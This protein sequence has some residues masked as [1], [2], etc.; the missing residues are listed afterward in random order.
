VSAAAAW[1]CLL[2]L[3]ALSDSLAY[4][5][6]VVLCEPLLEAVLR[7]LLHVVGAG[8]RDMSIDVGRIDGRGGGG[9]GRYVPGT[10]ENCHEV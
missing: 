6:G 3:Q 5:L 8:R 7:G 1:S 2:L 4:G 10:P 9:V